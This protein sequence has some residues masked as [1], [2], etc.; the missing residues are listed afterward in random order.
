MVIAF[1]KCVEKLETQKSEFNMSYI[2]AHL[3][4]IATWSFAGVGAAAGLAGFADWLRMPET[5]GGSWLFLG[6]ASVIAWA[7]AGGSL[8]LQSKRSLT[9]RRLHAALDAYALREVAGEERARRA[10]SYPPAFS[11][12]GMSHLEEYRP[13]I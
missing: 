6:V 3:W 8:W 5:N 9:E 13:T 4:Q 10:M 11:S 2:P 1:A 12:N 7:L